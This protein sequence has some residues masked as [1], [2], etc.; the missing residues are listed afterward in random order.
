MTR[1]AA[2]RTANKA[3]SRRRR[4]FDRDT[5]DMSNISSL[6]GQRAATSTLTDV[7]GLV[8]SY[9]SLQPDA[10]MAAHQVAFGTSGH[11]GNARLYSFNEWH[12]LAMTQA[13]CDYRAMQDI[14]GPLFLGIDT[15][16]LSAPAYA[17][18]L[19][20]LAANGVQTMIAR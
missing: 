5:N 16:A 4:L 1:R 19:E 8:T 7:A 9:F 12:V 10:A 6:A 14:N 17:S 2:L 13:I 20:V 18:T 11:R 3:S 15:H